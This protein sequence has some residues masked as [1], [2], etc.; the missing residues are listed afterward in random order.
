MLI[1]LITVL[2]VPGIALLC[3]AAGIL[4]F[5]GSISAQHLRG[6][7]TWAEEMARLEERPEPDD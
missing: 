2:A 7:Y 4:R 6:R 5:H 1:A 3:I